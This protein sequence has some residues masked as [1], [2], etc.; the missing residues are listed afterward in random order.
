[1]NVL[2]RE[3]GMPKRRGVSDCVLARS[4]AKPESLTVADKKAAGR[5]FSRGDGCRWQLPVDPSVPDQDPTA[6]DRWRPLIPG[7]RATAGGEPSKRPSD[8]QALLAAAPATHV[9]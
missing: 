3:G 4:A 8:G 5:N 9:P 6:P 1:M 7:L 2:L